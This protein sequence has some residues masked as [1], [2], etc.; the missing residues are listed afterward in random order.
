MTY[1]DQT[2]KTKL[3]IKDPAVRAVLQEDLERHGPTRLA[4]AMGLS[5]HAN[6]FCWKHV[7]SWY[8]NALA[9]Y[10]GRDVSAYL[11]KA[12]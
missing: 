9:G 4:K 7:P 1:T 8:I 11:P 5:S 2:K 3:S 6:I 12:A 10:T